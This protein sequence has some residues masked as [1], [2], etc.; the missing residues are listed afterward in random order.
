LLIAMPD[1]PSGDSKVPQNFRPQ[2]RPQIADNECIGVCGPIHAEVG[3]SP[4]AP[5]KL[6]KKEKASD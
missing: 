4:L 3:A 6:R 1:R 5:M 2:G